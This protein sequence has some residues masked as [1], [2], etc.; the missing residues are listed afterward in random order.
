[1]MNRQNLNDDIFISG[2]LAR[3]SASRER[4][5]RFVRERQELRASEEEQKHLRHD[6][7]FHDHVQDHRHAAGG[8][9]PRERGRARGGTH[10]KEGSVPWAGRHR[11]PPE[12]QYHPGNSGKGGMWQSGVHEVGPSK[13]SL[14]DGYEE[15]WAR[16]ETALESTIQLR[17]IPFPTPEEVGVAISIL[18]EK[19]ALKRH[20]LRWHPD[21]FL[22]RYGK[23]L[24]A[25]ERDAAMAKVKDAFLMA[26]AD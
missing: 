4:E 20:M 25:G 1:M 22:Q 9:D 12:S 21:K 16:F 7:Y 15:R 17:D 23:R 8:T 18:G 13:E 5:D 26:A 3:I 14:H 19:K 6:R 10:P 2:R 24:D 11:F